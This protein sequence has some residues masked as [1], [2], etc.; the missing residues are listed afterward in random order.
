MVTSWESKIPGP[1]DQ[2][3]TTVNDPKAERAAPGNGLRAHWRDL[4]AE[5]AHR[6]P[7]RAKTTPPVVRCGESTS[8]Q[9]LFKSWP[10]KS[11]QVQ[12]P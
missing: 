6:P 10:W 12:S 5:P 9:R 8:V 2:N 1:S 4:T 11:S 3:S 7:R